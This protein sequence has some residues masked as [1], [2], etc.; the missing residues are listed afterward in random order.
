MRS[1]TEPV[2]RGHV[3][4]GQV[5]L[6][7]A[8]LS[9]LWIGGFIIAAA[10]AREPMATKVVGPFSYGWVWAM[11]IPVFVL[12]VTAVHGRIEARGTEVSR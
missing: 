1:T 12:V 11:T 6:V 9:A 10:F 7:L 4:I 8:V 3:A 5:R 2:A